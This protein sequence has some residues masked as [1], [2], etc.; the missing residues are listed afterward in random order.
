MNHQSLPSGTKAHI[1]EL[2]K[3]T[4][5]W[6]VEVDIEGDIHDI[7]AQNISPAAQHVRMLEAE[8]KRAKSDLEAAKAELD[9]AREK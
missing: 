2:I 7:P 1:I 6:Q 5:L 4:G 3:E 9:A 8:L